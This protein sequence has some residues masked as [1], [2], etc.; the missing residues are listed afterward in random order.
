MG[1]STNFSLLKIVTYLNF[2]VKFIRPAHSKFVRVHPG[3]D[4]KS[5]PSPA[6]YKQKAQMRLERCRIPKDW[7]GRSQSRKTIPRDLTQLEVM[8]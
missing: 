3:V 1:Q 8:N 4:S 5:L 2:F 7:D 6:L